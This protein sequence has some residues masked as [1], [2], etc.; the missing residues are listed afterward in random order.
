MFYSMISHD[1]ID[2]TQRQLAIEHLSL[3]AIVLAIV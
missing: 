2:E 1:V 3:F